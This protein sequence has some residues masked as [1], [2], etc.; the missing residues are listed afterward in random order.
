MEHLVTSAN[1][2]SVARDAATLF[3]GTAAHAIHQRGRFNVVLS[4]GSTPRRLYELLATDKWRK[5]VDWSKVHFFWEDE[6]YVPPSD[7]DSNYRMTND[8]LLSKIDVPEAN[9]H[10]YLTETGPPEHVAMQYERMLREYFEVAKTATMPRF[11]LV[12]LGL[13]TNGHTASLF[14]G[15]PTLH[16][17]E[18]YVMADFIETEPLQ[19]R[20]T[21]SAPLLNNAR[22]Q[23][24][25]VTGEEKADVM[26]E[27]L[28]GAN[29]PERLPAQLI[30]PT[31]GFL[32]WF[33]D[34]AAAAKL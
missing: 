27:I 19:W 26:R 14:P 24:F 22:F 25:L 15:R 7:K 32:T 34:E 18:R 33:V 10:R 20:F 17:T 1:P 23:A 29:D 16:E 28:F 6:R 9:I 4:G 11:D 30:H 8:A 2:D 12:L 3:T 21:L 31:N 13:G 5:L